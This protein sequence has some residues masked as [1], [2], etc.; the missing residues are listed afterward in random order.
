MTFLL[1]FCPSENHGIWSFSSNDLSTLILPEVA[2]VFFLKKSFRRFIGFTN[3]NGFFS[4]KNTLL[5]NSSIFDCFI[6]FNNTQ[7]V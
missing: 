6:G 5:I 1:T 3:F 7:V 4:L 2:S